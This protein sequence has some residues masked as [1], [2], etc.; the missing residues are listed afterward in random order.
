V[1]LP[2]TS[3]VAYAYDHENRRIASTESG[4]TT[5]YLWDRLSAY[6]D[7]LAEYD[8]TEAVVVEYTLG[9]GRLISQERGGQTHYYLT[10]G[11]NST[12]NL[13]NELGAITDSYRYVAFGELVGS[14]G[15]TPN[16]YLYTGQQFDAATGQYSL[17]ARYYQPGVGR[18]TARDQW[19]YDF[20]NPVEFN[21][22]GYAAGNPVNSIDPS[23]FSITFDTGKIQLKM[24]EAQKSTIARFFMGGVVGMLGAIIGVI[25]GAL[26][27]AILRLVVHAATTSAEKRDFSVVIQ[28]TIAEVTLGSLA[29]NALGGFM[30][31]FFEQVAQTMILRDSS[32]L[33]TA[34]GK[35]ALGDMRRIFS[36]QV[37]HRIA[38]VSA[39]NNMGSSMFAAALLDN[40]GVEGALD[41]NRAATWVSFIASGLLGMTATIASFAENNP[42]EMLSKGLGISPVWVG[43]FSRGLELGFTNTLPYILDKL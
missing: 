42:F 28:E 10:D 27:L 32:S 35:D 1:V 6:G 24:A 18:F 22:Y 20:R 9:G 11:Q 29:V 14:T 31:G 25:T 15:S 7:V 40:A 8:S 36:R 43:S 16:K 3:S 12:R 5:S 33:I 37:I 21:R 4:Q 2:D 23:G 30:A 19:A 17:R 39:I 13:T 41:A 26:I 34:I 38:L